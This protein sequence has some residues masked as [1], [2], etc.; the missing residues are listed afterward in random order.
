[1]GFEME[2]VLLNLKIPWGSFDFSFLC[3]VKFVIFWQKKKAKNENYK[4]NECSWK[5]KMECKYQLWISENSYADI[6]VFILYF[7]LFF[8]ILTMNE[9]S[10][11]IQMISVVV[12][13]KF[14][15]VHT[16][17][18]LTCND[19][20]KIVIKLLICNVNDRNALKCNG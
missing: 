8:I 16:A 19:K 7:F 13:W 10:S 5:K 11:F 3:M 12:T 15:D 6:C 9:H 1:M 20:I 4:C 14:R 2:L 18:R 17:H